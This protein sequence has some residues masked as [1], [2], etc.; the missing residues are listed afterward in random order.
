MKIS[1]FIEEL[2]TTMYKYGDYE[3]AFIDQATCREFF[4]KAHKLHYGW[5]EKDPATLDTVFIIL[6]P[7][8][9]DDEDLY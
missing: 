5:F 3:V 9:D 4:T 6:G 8:T 2:K 7:A 1:E